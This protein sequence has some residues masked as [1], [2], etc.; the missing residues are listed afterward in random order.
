MMRADPRMSHAGIHKDAILVVDSQSEGCS[1][2]HSG[3]ESGLLPL[4]KAIA[5]VPAD[6]ASLTSE[7]EIAQNNVNS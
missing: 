1:R 3:L 7:Y 5:P 2:Q 6:W 4:S